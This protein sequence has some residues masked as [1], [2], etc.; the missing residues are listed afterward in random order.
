MGAIVLDHLAVGAHSVVG[1]GAVVTSNV[2]EHV[3]VLGV[4]ARITTRN[5][6]GR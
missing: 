1:A 6:D 4:P 5:V 2:P 3:Q